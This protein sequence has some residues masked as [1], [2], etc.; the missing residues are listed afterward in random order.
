MSLIRSF[1]F[2]AVALVAALAAACDGNVAG[3]ASAST[4]VT[5]AF[6]GGSATG[7]STT[8]GA[9]LQISGSS[10]T[11]SPAPTSAFTYSFQIKNSGPLDAS[12]SS[13]TDAIPVGTSFNSVTVNGS[14]VN[15]C[16]VSNPT[17]ISPVETLGDVVVNCN[18]G[19]ITKG[20]QAV[21]A[22]NVNAPLPVGSFSN[23]GTTT[24]G[25]SDPNTANNAVTVSAQVKTGS[26]DVIKVSKCY[27]NSGGEMLIK[28]ASSD[29]A[30]R[31]FA[32]RPDGTLIGEVQN[33]GGSRYG[34][35]VMPYQSYDPVNVTIR[36]TS[37]GSIAVPTGPFQL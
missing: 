28:A 34:G 5:P 26:T 29:A 7:G 35:T 22:L 18:L 33:G 14:L 32:Y 24:S 37:G 12:G 23:T 17:G 6:S 20:G 15:G 19:T 3:P 16:T 2:A 13:F 30:A 31:L 8:T 25:V 36:S 4:G 9:D 21:I 11:G 27:I 1:R 10:N